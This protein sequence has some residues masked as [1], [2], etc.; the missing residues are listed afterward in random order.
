MKPRGYKFVLCD[1]GATADTIAS[2][3]NNAIQR[4]AGCNHHNGIGTS[5]AADQYARV[6]QAGITIVG[7]FTGN[8]PGVAGVATEVAGDVCV[9]QSR[10]LARCHHCGQ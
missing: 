2:C 7:S 5:D 4:E 8:D 3:F 1:G 9:K 6:A 10:Q